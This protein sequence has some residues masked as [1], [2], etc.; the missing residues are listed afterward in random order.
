[1]PGEGVKKRVRVEERKG[2]VAVSPVSDKGAMNPPEAGGK[3]F[4]GSTGRK[5]R[6]ETR[7][8]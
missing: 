7:D 2:S 4:L 3:G 6:H 5:G 1:M 8:Q